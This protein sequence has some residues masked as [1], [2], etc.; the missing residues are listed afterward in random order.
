MG[1]VV[2]AIEPYTYWKP[3]LVDAVLKYGDRLY[4]MSIPNAKNPPYLEA[5]E[6]VKEFHVTNF[7]VSV[8]T[9]FPVN[10]DNWYMW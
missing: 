7:N 6:I 1:I 5:N 2:E 9:F 3:E 8:S 10:L 4:T